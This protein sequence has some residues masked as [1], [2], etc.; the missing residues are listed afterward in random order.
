MKRRAILKG[1]LLGAPLWMIARSGLTQDEKQQ[2]KQKAEPLLLE[3]DTGAHDPSTIVREG[4]SYWMFHTGHGGP[5]KFSSDLKSWHSGLPVFPQAP[6]W[7]KEIAPENRGDWWAPDIIKLGDRWAI[8]YSVSSFGKNT[9]AIG[10]TTN[11]TLNSF[12]TDY[13]WRDEGIVV[14]TRATDNF[15][16]IDAALTFDDENR[17]WMSF[18]SFWSGIKLIE[19]DTKTGKRLNNDLFS[20]AAPPP[21]SPAS[22]AP[23]IYRRGKDYFLFVNWG[24]CC[25]GVQS[26][27]EVRIGRSQK[28]TG[29]YLDKEGR[30]LMQGGGSLFLSRRGRFIGP[31]HIGILEDKN[32][33]WCSCHFYDEADNGRPT[34]MIEKLKFDKDGWPLLAT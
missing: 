23:C 11:R 27:Y 1:V 2:E 26:T 13:A 28:I 18:G 12:S 19:L 30:D 15:N 3:G 21:G 33:L 31:G 6:T 22:E 25:R 17:L 5:S 4:D 9:S 16:A 34:L 8:F 24:F 7:W 14:Q 20:I 32:E 29:P 10:L